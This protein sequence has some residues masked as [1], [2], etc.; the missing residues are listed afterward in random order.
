[1]TNHLSKVS[2]QCLKDK[3]IIFRANTS[4]NKLR[5]VI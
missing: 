1:M 4:D 2:N 5:I 3:V